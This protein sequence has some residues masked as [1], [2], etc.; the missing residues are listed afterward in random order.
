MEKDNT[1][2]SATESETLNGKK[3]LIVEDDYFTAKLLEKK[4]KAMDYTV[5]PTVSSGEKAI[6]EI[7]LINPDLIL[8]DIML[9]GDMDGV[10]TAK[11][12]RTCS[13]IPIIYLTAYADDKIIKRAVVT[14][15]F[16]YIIK[17]F[18]DNEIRTAIEIALYRYKMEMKLKESEELFRT[19]F[20]TAQD[21]MFIKNLDLRYIRVNPALSKLFDTSVE[22]LIGK[23]NIY[24]FGEE[25]G[26]YIREVDQRVLQGE[27][28]E[29]EVNR[30]INGVKYTFLMTKVHLRDSKGN[31]IG[32]F[33]TDRNITKRKRAEEAL[34]KAHDELESKVE[35]RT[36]EL[37]L[38]HEEKNIF[39]SRASHDLRTPNAAI[40]GFSKLLIQGK[41]ENLNKEQLE[42]VKKIENHAQRLNRIISDLLS[43]SRIESGVIGIAKDVV[44]ISGVVKEVIDEMSSSIKVKSQSIEFVD[45]TRPIKVIGDR[46]SIH[47]ILTNL[48]DNSSV[49]T[50]ENGEITV[51][52]KQH[53][54]KCIV[55]VKDTGIGLTKEDQKHI[56]DEFYRVARE[57]EIQS[58]GT[59]LGLAIAKRLI[60]QMGGKFWV[61]SEGLGNGST[62]SFS[63]PIN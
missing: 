24:I 6:E 14:Y 46:N 25:T 63:I 10:E 58:Q 37:K 8:M 60:T 28:I 49:Y 52:V 56:F 31:I 47:Q 18:E 21:F 62:F 11:Q 23:S 20:E 7:N 50:D 53:D 22:E 15:P 59:G 39:I 42:R 57:G 30:S 45:T 61:E 9:E 4:L 1:M 54:S 41:W 19:V 35:K 48:I 26:K 36:L 17:P 29:E 12:I 44:N 34:G 43:I 33:G 27:I 16:G 51:T 38:L 13:N 32:L 3:I 55:Q 40:L 2:K 5:L